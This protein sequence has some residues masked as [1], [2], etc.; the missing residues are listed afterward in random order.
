VIVAV[1]QGGLEVDHREAGQEAVF[2]RLGEALFNA[3]NEFLRHVAAHD[4]RLERIADARLDRFEH[5][6][7]LGELA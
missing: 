7:D 1:D 6:L 5:D 4:L 2:L 3:G